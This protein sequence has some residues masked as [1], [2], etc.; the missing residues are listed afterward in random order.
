MTDTIYRH[1]QPNQHDQLP[2]NTVCH[3]VDQWGKIVEVW[4]QRSADVSN[5]RWEKI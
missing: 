2:A 3:V 5:P 4:I 1:S